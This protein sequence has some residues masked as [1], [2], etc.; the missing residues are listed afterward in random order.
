MTVDLKGITLKSLAK[1]LGGTLPVEMMALFLA[2]ML[3]I[4]RQVHGAGYTHRDVKP[5]NFVLGDPLDP[6]DEKLYLIDF[7]LAKKYRDESGQ[8]LPY[9]EGVKVKGT[10]VYMSQYTHM[11]IEPSRRDD[12]ESLAYTAASLIK[13][14][15]PWSRLGH[16]TVKQ[17]RKLVELKE[18]VS[19]AEIFEGFPEEFPKFLQYARGL[20]YYEDPDYSYWQRVF[21]ELAEREASSKRT[22]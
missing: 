14:R 10:F 1:N 11:G 12:L 8:H 22:D 9:A 7:G 17:R 16:K 21:S 19:P 13:G 18:T 2:K 15:L 4:F 6:L 20:D 3:G 5:H